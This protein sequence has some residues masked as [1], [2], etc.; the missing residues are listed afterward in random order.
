MAS[1][2]KPARGEFSTLEVQYH[3]TMIPAGSWKCL[4]QFLFL[5]LVSNVSRIMAGRV[6]LLCHPRSSGAHRFFLNKFEALASRVPKVAGS[7][8]PGSFVSEIRSQGLH[9]VL[10]VSHLSSQSPGRSCTCSPA[11]T[12]QLRTPLDVSEEVSRT[13]LL[14]EFQDSERILTKYFSLPAFFTMMELFNLCP[15]EATT[16]EEFS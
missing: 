6:G 11:S 9:L 10:W 13:Y 12:T 8:M 5:F 15:L 16:D 4:L 2:T 1:S 14:L 7:Q 3:Q